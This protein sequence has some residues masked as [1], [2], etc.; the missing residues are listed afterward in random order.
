[1]KATGEVQRKPLK[2]TSLCRAVIRG[3]TPQLR[4]AYP[5]SQKRDLGHPLLLALAL[6]VLRVLADHTHHTAAIDDLALVTNF[7]Y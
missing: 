5:R 4:F 3:K 7:L 2:L 6:L 1:V